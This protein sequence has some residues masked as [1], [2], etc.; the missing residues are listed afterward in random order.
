MLKKIP[1]PIRNAP[2][3]ACYVCREHDGA[4]GTCSGGCGLWCHPACEGLPPMKGKRKRKDAEFGSCPSPAT[5]SRASGYTFTCGRCDAIVG[6][7]VF[8]LGQVPFFWP[9]R[10]IKRDQHDRVCVE[11]TKNRR[12]P[13]TL[14]PPPRRRRPTRPAAA[15]ARAAAALRRGRGSM[16]INLW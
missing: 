9:A 5:P 3:D 13:G 15:A 4:L 7:R 2:E 1:K 10:V 6:A 12:R 8:A 11:G 14:P 16:A